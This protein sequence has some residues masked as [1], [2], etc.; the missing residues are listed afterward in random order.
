MTLEPGDL[1]STGTPAGVGSAREPR[2]WLKPGSG[3]TE[4]FKD[5][6]QCPEMVVA[7]AGSFTMGSPENEVERMGA[8]GPQ[9]KVT[10]GK[11][12]AVSKFAVT[13]DQFEAFV[14]EA[15]HAA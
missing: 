4:W 5:C 1:V 2:V 8:E 13:F 7:P 10:I 12:F 3:K 11:P 9:H 14:R 6:P 15:N